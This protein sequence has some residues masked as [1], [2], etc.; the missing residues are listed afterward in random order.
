MCA[1]KLGR[2][3]ICHIEI[4]AS[5]YEQT[6]S[7]KSKQTEMRTKSVD[8]GRLCFPDGLPLLFLLSSAKC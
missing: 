8:W 7:A 3:K 1:N 2:N 6:T 5:A 4:K